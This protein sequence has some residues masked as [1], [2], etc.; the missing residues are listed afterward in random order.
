MVMRGEV[1][2]VELD[3]TRG[4]EI[5]KTRPCLII[6]PNDM[7]AVLPRI[8]V[9]PIT[10]KGHQLGCRPVTQFKGKKASILL[11]QIRSID[12]TRLGKR[13]GSIPKSIWHSILLD[14]LA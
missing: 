4:T 11:D 8:L 5:K 10:S 1:Y 6:S 13:M 9:A 3:P 2:W 14:M 12:K 7:N